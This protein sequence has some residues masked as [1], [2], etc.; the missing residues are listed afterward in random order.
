MD[1]TVRGNQR[2]AFDERSGPD[3]AICWI[4]GIS[5]RESHGPGTCAAG[6]REDDKASLDLLQEGFEADTEVDAA[7]NRESPDLPEGHI[8]DRQ[9]VSAVAGFVN[10]GSC[11]CRN[12]VLVKGEPDDHV[13][14]DKNQ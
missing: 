2:K 13:R 5:G 6:Y 12:L 10:D 3:D 9:A 11:F 8:R 1:R 14:V 4:F 7:P